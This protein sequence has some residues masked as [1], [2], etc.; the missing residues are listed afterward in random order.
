MFTEAHELQ[1]FVNADVREYTYIC[2]CIHQYVLTFSR[3]HKYI[4]RNSMQFNRYLL[5]C[6][7]NSEGPNC[8]HKY[9]NSNNNNNNNNHHTEVET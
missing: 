1:A 9:N 7:L 8:K 6:R 5:N 4:D 2:V 3:G